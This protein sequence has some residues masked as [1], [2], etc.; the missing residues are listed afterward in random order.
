MLVEDEHLT[1]DQMAGSDD[2]QGGVAEMGE[3]EA[4]P[5][6]YAR[7]HKKLFSTWQKWRWTP[8]TGGE[9]EKRRARQRVK[10]LA[11]VP[12]FRF[13]LAVA[14]LLSIL[15][16]ALVIGQMLLLSGI[17]SAIFL[18]H[19]GLERLSSSFYWLLSL[20]VAQAALIWGR[21]IGLRRG[22]MRARRS[23]R[24]RVFAHL[25][26]LGPCQIQNERSG[27]LVTTLGEGIEALDAYLARYLPQMALSVLIP[28]LILL[29]IL[30]ADVLSSLLLALTA[31]LI[32]LLLILIGVQ[33][34]KQSQRQWKALLHMSAHFLDVVQGLATLKA[35]GR[36]QDEQERVARI[37][38]ALREK[39]MST[40]RLA[41]LSGAVLEF[42][43]SMAIGLVA[44]VLGVR[45][46]NHQLTLQTALFVLLLVPEFYRPL[47]DLGAARHAA[48]EG[49]ASAQRLHEILATTPFVIPAAPAGS[50]HNNLLAEQEVLRPGPLEVV[51]HRVSCTYPG[52]P[53]PALR[54]VALT[55]PAGSC[56]ALVGRSGAGKSTLARVLLRL[57]EAEH[58][59]ITVN[60]QPF[61]G[62]TRD[63]WWRAVAWVPQRPYLF[64]GSVDDNI[65]LARPDASEEDVRAAA[66]LAGALD[67]IQG[68]P[69]GFATQVG[70]QGARLSA[71]QVQRIAL[72]R[73]FLKDAPLLILDEPTSS[74]DPASEFVIRRA[75][76]QLVR[77]RTVLVIAHRL[78]TIAA[79][80]RV[81]SLEDGR[82]VEA[83][84]PAEWL[85]RRTDLLNT[86]ILSSAPAPFQV[87]G[88]DEKKAEMIGDEAA[89]EEGADA[90]IHSGTNGDEETGEQRPAPSA[91]ARTSGVLWRLLKMQLPLSR[92]ALL[93]ALLGCVLVASNLGLLSLAIYLISAS[94]VVSLLALLTVPIFFVRLLGLIRP[95]ARYGE[96]CLSHDLTFR[97]L[98]RLRVRIYA[99]LEPLTPALQLGYRSGD[100][101]SRLIADV[102]ELQ[103]L[104]LH[105]LA[106]LLIAGGISALTFWLL[107]Q[108]SWQLAL[109]GLF[110]LLLAW[111][112]VPLLCWQLGRG[113]GARQLAWRAELKALLLDGLQGMADLLI[114]G[115]AAAYQQTIDALDARLSRSQ[116]RQN[117]IAGLQEALS[118]LLK[119][120]AVWTL[121]LLA[122]P[123]VKAG[124]LDA[125]Y[126]GC[127]AL[128]LLA[129]FEVVGPPGQVCQFFDRI[130]AAGRRLFALLDA[131]PVVTDPAHPLQLPLSRPER[132]C[133]LAFED[134]SFAYAKGREPDLHD[135]TLHLR[136]GSKV[137]LVG[138]SGAGKSTLLRLA[139]RTWDVDAGRIT[140]NGEDLRRYALRDLRAL[141]SV[142][143]Q[144]TYLF[145]ATLRAN[146]LL[147]RPQASEEELLTALE[148]ARLGA[149]VR[150]LPAGLDT[151]I[152][153]Q[154]QRLSGGERQRLAIARALLK[155]APLLLLD[156][157]TANLDAQTEREVLAALHTL[158]QGRTV[159]LVTHRLLGM[160]HMDEIIVLE[161][162]RILERGTHA[163]LLEGQGRYARLWELQQSVFPLAAT[164][165]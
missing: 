8:R 90:S 73:A 87:Y 3:D 16:T 7:A 106:P 28:L 144:D 142:V 93:A 20:I 84:T 91:E 65:R 88:A 45:L 44:V 120:G 36:S 47:R 150:Q 141:I 72:A 115:Q 38:E 105:L 135:I 131:P 104:Y 29:V 83:G 123:L 51:L 40:L 95:L 100:V 157:V 85:G 133:E 146:L 79:A 33:A 92:S 163:R 107:A 17:I 18:R 147:A 111:G 119:Q 4:R 68:L 108:W 56:T 89:L 143:T 118:E 96:R 145:N 117:W 9:G 70:E 50:L 52:N 5:A 160:E 10:V 43:T 34:E 22:T 114:S 125:I 134:V 154:G 12:E 57:M 130:R 1:D 59:A 15:G 31:P 153:E 6:R 155:D 127:L 26:T 67:F 148:Q 41:F 53:Q 110:F 113:L 164:E 48:L 128:A 42:L 86:A 97:L 82:L 161:D 60:G 156:E 71:G 140:L 124:Q 98:T 103:H 81:L 152:G 126:P 46:L 58:G 61:E 37:S 63:Q 21:E 66:R 64:H 165:V 62:M 158:M 151:W 162:G 112:G 24:R 74:L 27:E 55:L 122:I 32:P 19:A 136:A 11:L 121:L 109:S 35:L 137:A 138:S 159:L 102:D 14:I 39:T 101:L 139:M 49:R 75:L 116:A 132:G 99:C 54:E 69:Q 149:C 94:S 129:S 13:A 78:S 76:T 23:L 2:G 25:L 80:S 77:G 30:P